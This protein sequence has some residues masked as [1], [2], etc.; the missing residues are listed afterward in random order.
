[1][2]TVFLR[3]PLD[4]PA[5]WKAHSVPGIVLGR[6]GGTAMTFETTSYD[7]VVIGSGGGAFAA[8]IRASNLGKRVVMIER[9]LVGGTCVNTGCVPSKALLSAAEARHVALDRKSTRLNSSHVATSYAV[10]CLKK[11][12]HQDDTHR[13]R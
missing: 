12:D 4:L 7:L 5:H 8:A 1:M 11:K 13:S 3:F 6:P 9:D 10:F 2:S